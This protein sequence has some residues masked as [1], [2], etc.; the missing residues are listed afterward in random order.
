MLLLISGLPG[1]GKSTLARA[2]VA[3]FGGVHINS[4]LIRNDLGLRGHYAPGDKEKVY[5]AMLGKVGSVLAAGGNAVV[6]STFY[7]KNIRAPFEELA[8]KYGV[9]VIRIQVEAAEA[10]IRLRLQKTRPDS[11]ADFAV[12]EKI[13]AAFEPWEAPV[14]VVRSDTDSLD[15]QIEKIDQYVRSIHDR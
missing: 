1:S 5:A 7:K 2:Y 13:R 11:E 8:A 12:Y 9:P 14:L 6:D 10:V 3:R 4:D 15:V